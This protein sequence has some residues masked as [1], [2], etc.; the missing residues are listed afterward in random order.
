MTAPDL[1]FRLRDNGAAVFRV[2]PENPRRRLE[3]EQIGVLNI[4]TGDI[5]PRQGVTISAAEKNTIDAWVQNRRKVEAARTTDDLERLA[6]QLGL[7]S[8]WVHTRA[9]DEQLARVSD[10]LLMGMHDLRTAIVRRKSGMV[11]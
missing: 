9:T 1:Y 8:H 7:A 11:D 4:R 10:R 6:D 2:D 3:L 5:K